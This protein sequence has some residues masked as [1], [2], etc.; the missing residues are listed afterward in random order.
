MAMKPEHSVWRKWQNLILDDEV[1]TTGRSMAIA[2]SVQEVLFPFSDESYDCVNICSEGK[3]T[4][5]LVFSL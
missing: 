3:G 4:T 2:Y 1:M 5:K